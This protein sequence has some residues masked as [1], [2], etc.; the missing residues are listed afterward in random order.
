MIE[1]N[2]KVKQSVYLPEEMLSQLRSE[3]ER[4]ERP[5]SWVLNR[6]WRIASPQ[7]QS[8]PDG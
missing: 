2:R 4:L 6:A 1:R 5:M 8:M 7:I 3:A